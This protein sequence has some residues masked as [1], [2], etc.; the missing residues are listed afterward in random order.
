MK[1][2]ITALVVVGAFALPVVS[3]QDVFG[4]GGNQFTMDFVTIGD[5]GNAPDT[6][7]YERES[8]MNWIGSGYRSQGPHGS[9]DYEYRIARHEVSRGMIEVYNR[10]VGGPIIS[11]HDWSSLNGNGD[12]QPATG[13]SWNEAARFV[14]WLN[15]SNGYSAAYRF[16]TS[17]GNDNITLWA[18]GDAGYN[19]QNP[20]RNS[21]AYYFLPSEDEWY[22]AAYYDPDANSGSG[23]YWRYATGSN[24]YPTAIQSGISPGTAVYEGGDFY[25]GFLLSPPADVHLAGGLSPYGTMGQT[26]NVGEFLETIFSGDPNDPSSSRVMRGGGW[27][28]GYDPN[29]PFYNESLAI[30]DPLASTDS[31]YGLFPDRDY[32]DFG[33]RIASAA[34]V[35][36]EP[37]SLLLSAFGLGLLIRRK[38]P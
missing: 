6:I 21:N 26:G 18:S 5:A 31:V 22:K 37:S 4:S 32:S 19:P 30:Q 13:V 1:A 38:R 14:N 16:T 12:D 3:A 23:G 29:G 24:V 25:D 7:G 33:F 34:A 9:V 20:F 17:G 35:I 8:T 10:N 11:M 36:P 27:R 2:S 28:D 15:T